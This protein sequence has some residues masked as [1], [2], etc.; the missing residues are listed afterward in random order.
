MKDA[1]IVRIKTDDHEVWSRSWRAAL[2]AIE[3]GAANHC[4]QVG[5][6]LEG[7]VGYHHSR[8]NTYVL[9]DGFHTV[10]VFLWK[11]DGVT[12]LTSSVIP[13]HVPNGKANLTHVFDVFNYMADISVL[14]GWQWAGR[15]L[16]VGDYVQ[17][18]YDDASNR[19]YR[20]EEQGWTV[21]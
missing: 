21:I 6:E 18:F 13:V 2:N 20:C 4:L 7:G 8:L 14:T 15:S 5:V 10:N 19:L 9:R 16:S 17:I 3:N 1:T 12:P 11:P